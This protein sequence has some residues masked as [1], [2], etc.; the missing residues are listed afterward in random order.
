GLTP[1]EAQILDNKALW[2]HDQKKMHAL[3]DQAQ[4]QRDQAQQ[5][6]DEAQAKSE[7]YARTLRQAILSLRQSGMEDARVCHILGI[8]SQQLYEILRITP[9]AQAHSQQQS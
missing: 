5:Q 6:R 4:Q 1:E 7:R 8:S 9:A 2:W 3:Y